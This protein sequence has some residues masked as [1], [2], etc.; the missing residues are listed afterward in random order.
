M[1]LKGT[2]GI[3]LYQQKDCPSELFLFFEPASLRR[4]TAFDIPLSLEYS[5]FN[6]DFVGSFNSR[7]FTTPFN[8]FKEK[9]RKLYSGEID[10]FL[11]AHCKNVIENLENE[12]E[13]NKDKV[14]E[15]CS[16]IYHVVITIPNYATALEGSQ[17]Q[18]SKSPINYYH[19]FILE[20]Y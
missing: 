16:F 6:N 12:I 9:I 8:I 4:S 7:E 5:S 13:R 15:N 17:E 14:A 2:Q 1:Y 11:F 20:H 3:L 19:S 18:V 10:P